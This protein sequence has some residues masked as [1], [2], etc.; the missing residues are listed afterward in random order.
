MTRFC[1]LFTTISFIVTFA[2]F[3]ILYPI[4]AS[5]SDRISQTS[6]QMLGTPEEDL[7]TLGSTGKKSKAIYWVGALVGVALVAALAAG[8]GGDSGGGGDGSTEPADT[9]GSI[10]VGW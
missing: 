10:N 4:P 8:G 6:P 2:C 7:S 3:Q 1:K 5:A 9:D